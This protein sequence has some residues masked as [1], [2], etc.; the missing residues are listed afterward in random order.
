MIQ[1]NESQRRQFGV[2]SA[3]LA[4]ERFSPDI[5]VNRFFDRLQSL[6]PPPAQ[7]NSGD[8]PE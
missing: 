8:A 3:L 1:M 5:V 7:H 4:R 6:S 2:A